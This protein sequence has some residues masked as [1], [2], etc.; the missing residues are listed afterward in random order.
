MKYAYAVAD[1]HRAKNPG[2]DNITIAYYS[3][4]KCTSSDVLKQGNVTMAAPV[5]KS[6]AY[7]ASSRPSERC[8]VELPCPASFTEASFRCNR[9]HCS[10]HCPQCKEALEYGFDNFF[11]CSCGKAP[12]NS[13]EYLCSDP[14]HGPKYQAYSAK[15]L[16]AQLSQLSPVKQLNILILGETGVGKSTW[17]NGFAN[18]VQFST[19]AEAREGIPVNLIPSQFTMLDENCQ[20]VVV[21]LGEPKQSARQGEVLKA[22]ESATQEPRSYT[23]P[24]KKL[25][26]RLIDTPGVGD[27]R[28]VDVDKANFQ[29]VLKHISRFKEIHG[30]CILLKP[31]SA[32]L[33]ILFRFCISELLTH[34]HKDACRNIIFVFTNCRSTFYRPGDTYPALKERLLELKKSNDVTITLDNSTMYCMD[35]EPI[36]FLAAVRCGI[37]FSPVE[38]DN[39]LLSWQKSVDETNRLIAYI[40]GLEPHSTQTTISLNE[41]RRLILLLVEPMAEIARNIQSNMRAVKSHMEEL[42][43]LEQSSGEWKKKLYVPTIILVPE[44]IPY[45]MTVCRSE[46]CCKVKGS[47]VHYTSICHEVCRLNDIVPERYPNPELQKCYAMQLDNG[48]SCRVCGCR[49]DDHLHITYKQIEKTKKIKDTN[50]EKE[51]KTKGGEVGAKRKIIAI[52]QKRLTELE[53]ERLTITNVCSK[54]AI[55]LKKNAITPYND[56]MEQYLD[57]HIRLE[58]DSVAVGGSRTRLDGYKAMREAY[59]QERKVLEE[60]LNANKDA[61]DSNLTPEKICELVQSL[62]HLN[63]NGEAFRAFMEQ[64]EKGTNH[65]ALHLE[66]N[67][68]PTMKSRVQTQSLPKNNSPAA[69]FEENSTEQNCPGLHGLPAPPPRE[70]SLVEKTVGFFKRFKPW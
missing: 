58:E 68:M 23:F 43:V 27:T 26:I 66:R 45:P 19:L 49:W 57:H 65:A 61:E 14:L 50:V 42:E 37:H 64:K 7:H 36:R 10:W 31:N 56:S 44:E 2:F 63:I 34:L 13:F 38:F 4:G 21:S 54:F 39:F 30:I 55:F 18:Y 17:I 28:G 3:H 32:R 41:A 70:Q 29:A 35:N 62:Y 48:M 24:G 20:E 59:V 16:S 11:Y 5:A 46:K 12:A 51:L 22:G 15:D 69:G 33:T 6:T 25:L 47:V 1:C 53:N 9:G 8:I 60:N 67:Y 40:A 52:S